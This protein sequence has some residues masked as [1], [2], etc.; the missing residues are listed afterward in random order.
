M[1]LVKSEEHLII[2][3]PTEV[4]TPVIYSRKQR[5]LG[6]QCVLSSSHRRLIGRNSN[7]SVLEDEYPAP[8]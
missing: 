6:P 1:Y 2:S 4:I 3:K 7:L 5:L 8:P